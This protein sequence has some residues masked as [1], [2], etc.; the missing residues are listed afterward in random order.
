MKK[1]LLLA[2]ILISYYSIAQPSIQWQKCLGGSDIDVANSI[3]CT[4]DGGFIVVGSTRSNNGNVSGNNGNQDVWIVKTSSSGSIEW[5]KCI[6]GS[7]DDGARSIT[8]TPDGGYI[9][10]GYT[11]SNNGDVTGNHGNTDIWVVKL[12]SLGVIQWQKCYGGTEEDWPNSILLTTDSGFIIS[13]FTSS[14]DGDVIGNHGSWEAWVFK[15]N[16]LGILEWQRCYGGS[17][18]DFA[19]SIYPTTDGNYVIAGY[20]GS[21]DGDVLG[22]LGSSDAWVV[23]IAD[24]GSI[25]WQKCLGSYNADEANKIVQTPDGGFLMVGNTNSIEGDVSG[26]HGGFRDSW[27]VKISSLGAIQWQ[28]CLGG[29]GI[30]YGNSILLTVDGGA[31]I[32]NITTSSDGDVS[33]YFGGGGYD[34]WLVK[35]DGLGNIE[36][37]KCI[38]GSGTE[39]LT[40][41]NPT[42][43]NGYVIAGSTNSIN[44]DVSGSQGGD[45][46]WVVKLSSALGIETHSNIGV[47]LYPNPGTNVVTLKLNINFGNLPYI[48]TDIEGK[49]IMQGT[50]SE[51]NSTI[52]I[53]HLSKGVYFI[54][55]ADNQSV[56]FIKE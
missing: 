15:I 12:S 28:R 42:I 47:T 52:N 48:V 44:G 9:V 46:A 19:N 34:I 50:V 31:I 13:G 26:N 18:E 55:V 27:V 35:L 54:T 51:N 43:H 2:I 4:N 3:Q 41:L 32:G 56:K 20:T 5:Q 6:G 37:Q 45:D 21:F 7:N 29:S 49:I 1:I 24:T 14:N 40:G 23:K 22:H 53:E 25:L 30:D 38:G 10:A 16:Q 39:Y 33:G 17:N 36:W 11:Y 8:I